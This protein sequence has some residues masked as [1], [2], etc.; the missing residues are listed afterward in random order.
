MKAEKQIREIMDLRMAKV[1]KVDHGGKM[2]FLAG[3]KF[4][5]KH[6]EI[7]IHVQRSIAWQN[8]SLPEKLRVNLRQRSQ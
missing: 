2:I 1:K 3:K 4:Y 8:K 5:R 7:A 6:Y